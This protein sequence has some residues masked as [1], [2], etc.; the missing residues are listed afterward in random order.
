M[1]SLV[2]LH[3]KTER[4]PVARKIRSGNL[5][6]IFETGSLRYISIGETEIIRMIYFAVRDPDW[7]TIPG[8]ISGEK[9]T[10]GNWGTRIEFRS[11]HCLH[12]INFE[13]DFNLILSKNNRLVVEMKGIALS[14]FLKN[15][16]GF[17]LLHPVASCAG[18]ECR[19]M[20]PDGTVT[21]TRFPDTILPH[22]PFRNI[23]AMQWQYNE[24][25]FAELRF[26]GDVFETE[27][28]RNW[29]DASFKTYCTP[30]DLPYPVKIQ[31]GT[32]LVQ[33]IELSLDAGTEPS[34]KHQ[35]NTVFRISG[36]ILGSLPEIGIGASSGLQPLTLREASIIRNIKFSHLRAELHLFDA[37]YEKQ[38]ARFTDESKNTGLPLELCLVFG[39]NPDAEF[40]NFV[41]IFRNQPVIL[42]RFLVLSQQ[43]KTT[44][45]NLIS[46][47]I[48]ALRVAFPGI[49]AGAGTNCNFAELNRKVPSLQ[50]IDFITFAI[51]PQEHA[52]D[53]RSLIENMAAQQYAVL[54]ARK[55]VAFKPVFIS[56]VTLQRRFNANKST[57]E[58]SHTGPDLPPNADPRQMSL[59][60]AAW[61]VGSLKYLIESGAAGIAYYE[62]TGERGIIMGDRASS[63]PTQFQAKKGMLF[64][65]FQVFRLLLGNS[66]QGFTLS[67]STQPLLIDGFTIVKGKEGMA[68]LSNMSSRHQQATLAGI[69]HFR[70]LFTMHSGN[71]D[72]VTRS[73]L[74]PGLNNPAPF[75][76]KTDPVRFRP[77]ETKVL[78]FRWNQFPD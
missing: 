13:A 5:S 8:R 47:I 59:F 7:L 2:K 51:H 71:F 22:Q 9:T 52:N 35:K 23:R 68:F 65:V 14:T 42:K 37:R 31:Q 64:P 38:Y 25:D 46:T 30:L 27:D 70:E 58:I 12:E 57:Y 76:E 74:D 48:P 72:L 53:N 19:I 73:V 6:L 32:T 33:K 41:R 17:C 50:E 75:S 28:Q 34:V 49:P 39:V 26:E 10:K 18:K 36:E 16:I 21:S 67:Q 15:R 61:T 55:L 69:S 40:G 63:W 56:P 45:D 77:Y 20:H 43:D 78:Q 24:S 1:I 62:T 4:F 3:G 60:A 11:Q 29:T 44:P 54:S 66:E